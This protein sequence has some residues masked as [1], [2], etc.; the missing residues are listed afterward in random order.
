MYWD[1]LPEFEEMELAKYIGSAIK[2]GKKNDYSAI[3]IIGQRRKTKQMYVIDGNIYK[4]LPDDLFQ[5]AIDK[6]K[7]YL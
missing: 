1:R 3:L 6:L 4:L 5:V 2:A 7:P